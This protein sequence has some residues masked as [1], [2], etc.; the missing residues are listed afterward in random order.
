MARK[1]LYPPEQIEGARKGLRD[2][3][4]A[5]EKPTIYTRLRYVSR[6][7]MNRSISLYVVADGRI[8]PIDWYYCRV[9]DCHLDRHDGIQISGCGMDVGFEATYN[10]SRVLYYA[11]EGEDSSK[12]TGGYHVKHEWL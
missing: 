6:N 1:P 2:M 8:V 7:G 12:H 9:M 11:E 10:L 4:D 3:L 5:Q